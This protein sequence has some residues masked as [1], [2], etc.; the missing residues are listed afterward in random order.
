M[1]TS[2]HYIDNG[3]H[4]LPECLQNTTIVAGTTIVDGDEYEDMD[5]RDADAIRDA[6][7]ALG[8]ETEIDDTGSL[9][10]T[11]VAEDDRLE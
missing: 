8:I 11:S 4:Y 6:C 7:R 9:V 1:K 10:A 5:D 2:T 3:Q